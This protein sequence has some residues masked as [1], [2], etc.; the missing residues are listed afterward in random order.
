MTRAL[1]KKLRPGNITAFLYRTWG[2]LVGSDP[3][4][5][6]QKQQHLSKWL[7]GSASRRAS[8]AVWLRMKLP[9]ARQPDSLRGV[10]TP[11]YAVHERHAGPEH[12]RLTALFK[13]KLGML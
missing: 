8:G 7:P 13:A 12:A 2:Q 9:Y 1:P 6:R 4:V 10:L 5:Q 3:R 11:C